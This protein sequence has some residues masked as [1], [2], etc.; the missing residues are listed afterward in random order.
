MPC[1]STAAAPPCDL[2]F[3]NT[4]PNTPFQQLAKCLRPSRKRTLM[5]LRTTKL[6]SNGSAIRFIEIFRDTVMY[7]II[8]SQW[9][10]VK[11]NLQAKLAKFK[12]AANPDA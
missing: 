4:N 11:N 7:S 10:A 8:A 1:F 6:Y 2:T 9:T 3:G 5:A 12:N